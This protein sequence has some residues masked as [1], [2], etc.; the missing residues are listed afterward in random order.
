MKSTQRSVKRNRRTLGPADADS[1]L[2]EEYVQS[3]K[4]QAERGAARV[5]EFLR[6][7]GVSGTKESPIALPA[8]MLL[9]LDLALRFQVWELNAITAHLDAG[10]PSSDQVLKRVMSLL[11]G[12]ELREYVQNLDSRAIQILREQFVWQA[13]GDHSADFAIVTDGNEDAFL[14]AL[15][16]FL[17]ANRHNLTTSKDATQ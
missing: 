3:L 15:A 16:D 4:S 13:S 12:N 8:E 10:L 14:D 11:E 2:P 7:F 9:G 1:G 5:A 17:W 6:R